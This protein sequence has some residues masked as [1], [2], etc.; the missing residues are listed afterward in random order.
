MVSSGLVEN[1][2]V[3]HFRLSIHLSLA[4]FLLSLIFWYLLDISIVN[5]FKIKLSNFLL[6]L[7]LILIIFQIILG[8]FLSGLDG[9]LI[10]NS[11]PLMSGSFFPNDVNIKDYLSIQLFYNPSIIQFLH[12][13][14][15][16]MLFLFIIILNY[17]Y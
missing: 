15:A 14:V 1:N 2:D 6:Y 12:R 5:K 3:S 7:I 13:S 4:L 16:Y 10:Y 8:S 17:F 11:W 9:G